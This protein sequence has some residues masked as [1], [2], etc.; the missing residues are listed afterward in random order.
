M[1]NKTQ[2]LPSEN[3]FRFESLEIFFDL[4]DNYVFNE[5]KL[6]ANKRIEEVRLISVLH[7]N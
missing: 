1:N 6:I 5:E 3:Y 4:F 7:S 2:T